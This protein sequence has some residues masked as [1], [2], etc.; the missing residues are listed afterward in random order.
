[1]RKFKISCYLKKAKDQGV[2]F[3]PNHG[4]GVFYIILADVPEKLIKESPGKAYKE[5]FDHA[6]EI[7]REHVDFEI[8]EIKG[9]EQESDFK[10]H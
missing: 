4:T 5:M 6:H 10:F 3:D 8:E 1:M 9:I 7:L 2:I